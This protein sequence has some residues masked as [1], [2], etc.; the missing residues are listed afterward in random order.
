MEHKIIVFNLR[1]LPSVV[2]N[3]LTLI[4]NNKKKTHCVRRKIRPTCHFSIN[5]I[6]LPLIAYAYYYDYIPNL[7][8]LFYIII[9][10][11]IIIIRPDLQ[12]GGYLNYTVQSGVEGW[13]MWWRLFEYCF[14]QKWKL[15]VRRR[16]PR[17][18]LHPL[19][20]TQASSGFRDGPTPRDTSVFIVR[21]YCGHYI[22]LFFDRVQFHYSGLRLTGQR[23]EPAFY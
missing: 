19:P 16:P 9:I 11:I 18:H 23:E 5:T 12:Y 13:Q 10:I 20:P 4:V 7:L 21:Y 3:N 2:K 15:S 17:S 8:L 22:I 1:S 14:K 6:L